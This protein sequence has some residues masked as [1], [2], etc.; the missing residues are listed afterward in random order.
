MEH[1]EFLKYKRLIQCYIRYWRNI[2][3]KWH[4]LTLKLVVIKFLG[5]VNMIKDNY[6][7]HSLIIWTWIFIKHCILIK[8]FFNEG[9]FPSI[10][11]SPLHIIHYF[12]FH[13]HFNQFS[14]LILV[15]Q[16]IKYTIVLQN[17]KLYK[18]FKILFTI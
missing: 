6:D 5:W 3:F 7:I 13:V 2:V 18:K 1:G 12:L 17:F 8:L 11:K 14:C 15:N 9:L 4:R 10:F 16:I